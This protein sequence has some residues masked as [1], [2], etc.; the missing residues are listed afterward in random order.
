MTQQ[1]VEFWFEYGST[2]TYLTVMRIEDQAG[3]C[4][5]ETVSADGGDEAD[6]LG[7]YTISPVSSQG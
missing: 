6:G 5:M 3:Q 2:Y 1:T 4:G 7:G